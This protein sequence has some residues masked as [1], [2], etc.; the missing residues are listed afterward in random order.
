MMNK[1][2]YLVNV[3]LCSLKQLGSYLIEPLYEW[4][5]RRDGRRTVHTA[6]TVSLRF[7]K[8]FED[9]QHL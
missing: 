9:F 3:A 5:S 7:D 6:V 1:D 2:I 4:L 8:N